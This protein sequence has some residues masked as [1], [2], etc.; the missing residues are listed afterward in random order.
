MQYRAKIGLVLAVITALAVPPLLTWQEAKRQ[1]YEIEAERALS[2]AGDVLHRADAAGLQAANGIRTLAQSGLAPC[3][4]PSR[5]LMR[6]INLTS[7]YIQATGY[8]HDGH[9]VC[10]SLGDVP[11]SLGH[12][13]FK[14]S[15][16]YTFYLD[17]SPD[18][19]PG[20]LLG[21][22]KGGYAVLIHRDLPLDIWT[23]GPGVSLAV[24]HPEHQGGTLTKGFVDAG[25]LTRLGTRRSI[26]FMDEGHVVAIVHSPHF[27]TSALAAVPLAQ[28]SERTYHV[29]L[30]LVPAGVL[31]GLLCAGFILLL[32]R[33]RMSI[34]SALRN[35]LR[36]NEF[37]LLYQPLTELESG[38]VIGVEALLRWRRNTG[39]LVSPEIF[40]PI[41]EQSGLIAQLT[42]R[43]FKLVEADAGNYLAAH[44]D[45][46]IAI[47]L[48]P[49]DL[50]TSA[51]A[52]HIDGILTRTGACPSNLIVEITERGFLDLD[53]ARAT[54]STLRARGI[55]VA[56]D[57]FGT[58][59]SSLSYL[60]TL[61]LD[62]LKI[63]R[64]FIEA[65]GTGA[66]TSQV[67]VHII[68]MAKTLGLKMIAEG[69]E[70]PA[71]HDFLLRN[72]V[73]YA[74]GWLFG[75][76]MH[77]H[78]AVRAIDEAGATIVRQNK[79]A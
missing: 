25:W 6:R 78:E 19:N 36:E 30:R 22:E 11:L 13:T 79:S 1:A 47:N 72:R 71:Q 61:Q 49:A 63:D 2:Y 3:S 77:F 7:P 43:V 64:S 26:T 34:P 28:L 59:Y 54:I 55:R 39:E 50:Q 15:S 40:I 8:V 18:S 38:S 73:Q 5:E 16:G 45:F 68:A 57:D 21:V 10:S 74:Q 51:V 17:V 58:G 65:I 66:P 32:A 23:T 24:L 67:V 46:H 60:E 69:V 20:P 12:N 9:L 62:Y 27:L 4:A 75:K 48:A 14:A 44:P 70:S 56:I 41:A 33:R 76:P 29:A 52:Q 53:S 35:A 37:F 31:A 42:E